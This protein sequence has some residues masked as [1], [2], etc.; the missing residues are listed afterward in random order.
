MQVVWLDLLSTSVIIGVEGDIN[1]VIVVIV[2]LNCNSE[3]NSERIPIIRRCKFLS[4]LLLQITGFRSDPINA[5][6]T[7]SLWCILF[8]YQKLDNRPSLRKL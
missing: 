7:Q 1:S 8:I 4:E 3:Q 6:N 5:V 2:F